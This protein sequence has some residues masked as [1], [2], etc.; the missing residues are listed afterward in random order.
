MWA[1]HFVKHNYWN[2]HKYGG[3]ESIL[4]DPVLDQKNYK[5]IVD[6]IINQYFTKPNY[7]KIDGCPV[8]GI[9]SVENFLLGFDN[10]VD[11]AA[12]ALEYFREKARKAGF[13]GVH[14]QE[15]PGKGKPLS[16]AET[17][18]RTTQGTPP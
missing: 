17:A 3:D 11:K 15:N 18:K 7:L 4:F 5:I 2:W 10:N 9:F 1:N 16:E 12:E 6:R 14:F 13:K 8:F